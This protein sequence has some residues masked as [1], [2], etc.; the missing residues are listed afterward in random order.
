MEGFSQ[1]S[2]YLYFMLE[3]VAGGEL[4]AYL[5]STGALKTEQAAYIHSNSDYMQL[6]WSF[7][8]HI[9]MKKTLSTGT[10]NQ[11]IF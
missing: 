7:A 2:R 1:D 4:F 9:F 8:S 10:S 3:F 11:R 5:R 6:K